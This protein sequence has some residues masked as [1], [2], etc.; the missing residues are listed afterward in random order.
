MKYTILALSAVA[1]CAATATAF[2]VGP[3]HI[4]SV[5]RPAAQVGVA[6]SSSLKMSDTLAAQE[7]FAK[8]EIAAN[9]V[10]KFHA[11]TTILIQKLRIDSPFFAAGCGILEILL[12]LLCSNKGAFRRTRYRNQS[13]RIGPDGRG[14]PST[15]TCFVANVRPKICAKYLY[16]GN[17]HWWKFRYPSS[18]EGWKAKRNAWDLSFVLLTVDETTLG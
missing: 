16:Q 17:P 2:T 15:S 1:L 14:W 11:I 9:T 4:V 8:S 13:P 10:S 3:Q 18:C 5:V 12:S 7:S 6:T